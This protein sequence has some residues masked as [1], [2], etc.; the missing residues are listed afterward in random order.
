MPTRA[1]VTRRH[2]HTSPVKGAP[3]DKAQIT[4]DSHNTGVAAQ[5]HQERLATRDSKQLWP[6]VCARASA[7]PRGENLPSQ[8]EKQEAVRALHLRYPLGAP[9]ALPN[10]D[11][12]LVLALVLVLAPASHFGPER[13]A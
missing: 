9:A 10:K 3:G 7:G 13:V 4:G 5:Y 2:S 8:P 1:S 11:I 6:C 12:V